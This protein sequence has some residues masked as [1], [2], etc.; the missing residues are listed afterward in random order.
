[1]NLTFEWDSEKARSNLRRH[2]IS[3]E[4]ASSVFGD[5]LS[6]TIGDTLHSTQEQR[7][8]TMGESALKKLIIVSHVDR[9]DNIRI[10]SAR[11]ATKKERKQYEQ[12]N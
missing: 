9:G 5:P 8:I 2:G 11:L 4:E 1:M 6:I 7:F 3:F 12:S 10:L